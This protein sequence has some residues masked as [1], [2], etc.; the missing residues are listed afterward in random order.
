[1]RRRIGAT[2][3]PLKSPTVTKLG[4]FPLR[5]GCPPLLCES[6]RTVPQEHRHVV[7]G[8]VCR[9]DVRNAVAVYVGCPQGAGACSHVERAALSF[10]E[11]AWPAIPSKHRNIVAAPIRNGE[12]CKAIFIKVPH[13]GLEAGTF[14][15]LQPEKPAATLKPPA[16][17]AGGEP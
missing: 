17:S 8:K 12:V 14:L 13:Y 11:P 1:M 9:G 10:G 4:P 2:A 15:H 16:P 6:T 7:A 5:T 3:P